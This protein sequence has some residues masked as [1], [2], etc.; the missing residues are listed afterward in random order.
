MGEIY[1]SVFVGFAPFFLG[2]LLVWL[3]RKNNHPGSHG[4]SD[5]WGRDP[6]LPVI[7]F[8]PETPMS[9]LLIDRSEEN[10]VKEKISLY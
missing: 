4:G 7:P 10:E 2:I 1:I 6:G 9:R 8:P 5:T 3:F